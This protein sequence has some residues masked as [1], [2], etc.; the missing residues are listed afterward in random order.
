MNVSK[1]KVYIF[2]MQHDTDQPSTVYKILNSSP[3][4]AWSVLYDR[5]H[6]SVREFSAKLS[7]KSRSV[8]KQLGNTGKDFPSVSDVFEHYEGFV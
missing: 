7:T 4:F 8:C 2:P 1:Q 6:T 5:T 3:S